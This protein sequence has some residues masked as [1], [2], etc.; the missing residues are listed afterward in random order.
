MAAE[1]RGPGVHHNFDDSDS[2]YEMP[3]DRGGLLGK[4]NGRI[5]LLGDGSEIL[6][7]SEDTEMFDQSEEDEDLASQAHKGEPADEAQKISDAL[8]E[9]LETPISPEKA[10]A[11]SVVLPKSI[12][13]TETKEK[14][15]K[16]N[17]SE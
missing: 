1:F 10:G 4:N 6:T 13:S 9:K 14:A 8:P 17:K 15:A 11:A 12:S 5:I 7:G 2:G 3:M 16:E